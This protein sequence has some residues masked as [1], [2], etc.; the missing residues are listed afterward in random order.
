MSGSL[1]GQRLQSR[2]LDASPGR[3]TTTIA[4]RCAVT[5]EQAERLL[6]LARE[7]VEVAARY[8]TRLVLAPSEVKRNIKQLSDLIDEIDRAS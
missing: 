7:A 3:K 4:T 6:E 2:P 1:S 8:K 5:N